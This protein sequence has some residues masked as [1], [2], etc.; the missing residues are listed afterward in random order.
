MQFQAAIKETSRCH[1]QRSSSVMA[2]ERVNEDS[3]WAIYFRVNHH[4]H[5]THRHSPADIKLCQ[6]NV[7]FMN[8]TRAFQQNKEWE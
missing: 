3:P 2:G 7:T 4:G 6:K 5:L 1:T 8:Y